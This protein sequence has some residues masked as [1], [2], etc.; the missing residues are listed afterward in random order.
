MLTQ[1]FAQPNFKFP[2]GWHAIL[3]DLTLELLTVESLYGSV[4]ASV[5]A[6]RSEVHPKLRVFLISES[7]RELR[8][9]ASNVLDQIHH[10]IHD[11]ARTTCSI[12]GSQ[13]RGASVSDC[14]K[15]SGT[16]FV[17]FTELKPTK[18]PDWRLADFHIHIE[19]R[20]HQ[21]VVRAMASNQRQMDAATSFVQTYDA[22]EV[23][24]LLAQ[25]H[26]MRACWSVEDILRR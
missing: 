20:T 23:S 11:R 18:N 17:P 13:A 7:P 5:R 6:E 25:A 2:M 19:G 9:E 21:D 26:S 8:Q 14:G 15:H 12:C 10:R 24:Q 4:V 22:P 16:Q 1:P 3:H